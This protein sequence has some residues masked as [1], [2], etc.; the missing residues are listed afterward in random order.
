MCFCASL[1]EQEVSPTNDKWS[2]SKDLLA[3]LEKSTR[4]LIIRG[5]M[6]IFRSSSCTAVLGGR[7]SV[8]SVE[9][10]MASLWP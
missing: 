4:F 7:E 1:H 3:V 9:G 2:N 5:Q 10:N 6:D 8:E